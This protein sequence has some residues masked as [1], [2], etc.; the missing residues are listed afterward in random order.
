VTRHRRLAGAYLAAVLVAAAVVGLG[1]VWLGADGLAADWPTFAA[2][3]LAAA[4][5]QLFRVRTPNNQCYHLTLAV[6]VPAIFV[7]PLGWLLLLP[8]A[9]HT[10]EQ[11]RERYPLHIQLFNTANYTLDLAVAS[12]VA[13]ALGA[14]GAGHGSLPVQAA[15]GAAFVLVNHLLLAIM[16][17]LARGH[18]LRTSGL[19]GREALATDLALAGIGIALLACWNVSPWLVPL[20]IAPLALVH[21]SLVERSRRPEPTIA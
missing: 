8:L 15:A 18:S 6:L 9:Q 20:G 11:L 1:A 12:G 4:A 21:R 10:P 7:L 19:F 5:T 2:F 3:A 13:A 16:L 14:V 17:R